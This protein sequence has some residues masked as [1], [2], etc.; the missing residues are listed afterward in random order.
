MY[1][2]MLIFFTCPIINI[3]KLDVD[4][5]VLLLLNSSLIGFPKILLLGH[6][7][8]ALVRDIVDSGH[9]RLREQ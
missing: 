2:Y 7:V 5:C 6:V 3:T 9:E 1:I 4:I 8:I